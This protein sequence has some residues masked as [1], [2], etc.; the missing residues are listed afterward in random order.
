[1]NVKWEC[2]EGKSMEERDTE[3]GERGPK[4]TTCVLEDGI[5]KLTKHCKQRMYLFKNLLDESE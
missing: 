4:Y 1:M 3:V 2:S 5:M